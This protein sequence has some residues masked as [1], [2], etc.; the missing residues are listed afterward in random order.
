MTRV[1]K[2]TMTTMSKWKTLEYIFRLVCLFATA[3]LVGYW[4]YKFYLDADLS[5][6]EYK[7][8][9]M[10]GVNEM[11]HSPYLSP[12]IC[13]R[14]PFI[15]SKGTHMNDTEKRRVNMY[16]KGNLEYPDFKYNDV[17]LN[18]TNYVKRYKIVWRNGTLNNYR[19]N[20]MPWKMLDTGFN[21]FWLG[22]FFR[23]FTFKSPNSD[24]AG[25]SMMIENDVHHQGMFSL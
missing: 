8:Y 14:N 17:A 1:I 10:R 2:E 23:C 15:S 22:L 11:S 12:T 5:V 16:L 20:R 3:G 21:G 18:L 9:D 25:I 6:V 4:I 7:L 19:A 13:F 24:V